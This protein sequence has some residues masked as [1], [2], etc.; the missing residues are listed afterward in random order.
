VGVEYILS[1]QKS[2]SRTHPAYLSFSPRSFRFCVLAAGF[3]ANLL[4]FGRCPYFGG[5]TLPRRQP[6][7]CENS[8]SSVF[9]SSSIC[10]IVSIRSIYIAAPPKKQQNLYPARRAGCGWSTFA[11][12]AIV[13]VVTTATVLTNYFS[14]ISTHSPPP[15]LSLPSFPPFHRPHRRSFYCM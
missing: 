4:E 14:F 11:M 1:L 9:S 6:H 8:A 5:G 13:P 10:L 2:V 15:I 7:S 12:G 3:L